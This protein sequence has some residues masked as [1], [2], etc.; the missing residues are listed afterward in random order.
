VLNLGREI[1]DSKTGYTQFT[2]A[3]RSE[4]DAETVD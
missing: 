1:S 2:T 4:T 3:A